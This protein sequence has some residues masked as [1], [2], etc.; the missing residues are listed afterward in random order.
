MKL[1]N[2]EIFNAKGPLEQLMNERLPVKTAY[3]LAKI[4]AKLTAQLKVIGDVHNGLIRTYGVPDPKNRNQLS[5][6]PFIEQTD[7][8][9]KTVTVENPQFAKFTAERDELMRMESEIVFDKVKLPDTL[10]IPAT[11]VMALE[12]FITV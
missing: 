5:V 10:E 7:A 6:L 4:A 9:G 3:G 11:V 8:A 2:M 12:K 1:T